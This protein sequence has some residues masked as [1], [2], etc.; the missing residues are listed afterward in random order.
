MKL[1]IIIPTLNEE[2]HIVATLAALTVIRKAGHEVIVSDGESHDRTQ[3]LAQG[4]V[5]K[6]IS[7]SKG[8]ARQ[9]NRGAA[10]AG[11]DILVFLH[12]DTRLPDNA[13]QY[14]RQACSG[15]QKVWGYFD[16]ALDARGW[17]FRVIETMIN[18]RTGLTDTAS[19]DQALFIRRDVFE[20]IAGFP[21][22]ELMED[23]A[24]SRHLKRLSSPAR[25]RQRVTSSSR[26]WQ[27]QGVVRTILLMWLLRLAYYC[28]TDPRRLSRYYRQQTG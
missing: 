15:G 27:H 7:G 1:S 12:A 22:I 13:A 2:R 14:I 5:D 6:I 3:E 16:I 17:P 20:Q 21:D 11:G 23:L 19:G 28:G 9:M 25:I 4:H 10:R 18:F 8:R 24:M 26:R